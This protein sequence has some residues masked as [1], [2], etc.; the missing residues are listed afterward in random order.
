MR[1]A[2]RRLLRCLPATGALAPLLG[3]T[4]AGAFR[5][6][7]P[8]AEVAAEYG[9]GCAEQEVHA[10]LRAELD[11]LLEGRP[12]PAGLAPQLAGL[13]RCPFCGCAV[14][15]GTDHGEAAPQEG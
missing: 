13:A 11:R 14:T 15:G 7:P 10:A 12:L 2:R 8:S 3:A 5:L 6:E 4:A 1:T 9:G